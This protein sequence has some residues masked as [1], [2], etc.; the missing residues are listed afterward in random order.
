MVV[1]Q[2]GRLGISG[3]HQSLNKDQAKLFNWPVNVGPSFSIVLL[4]AKLEAMHCNGL[5][6]WSNRRLALSSL[7]GRSCPVPLGTK[8]ESRE[9]IINMPITNTSVGESQIPASTNDKYAKL[10]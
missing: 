7:D 2:V 9:Q 1:L 5:Q 10:Q 6:C 4:G 3:L 8:L